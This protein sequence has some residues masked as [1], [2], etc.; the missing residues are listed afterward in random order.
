[1]IRP[2]VSCKERNYTTRFGL[3][4]TTTGRLKS[5]PHPY[6]A[7]E[8]LAFNFQLNRIHECSFNFVEHDNTYDQNG[9]A[10]CKAV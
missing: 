5:S 7:L 10:E 4:S 8:L 1:M 2:A 9:D 6:I 3:S